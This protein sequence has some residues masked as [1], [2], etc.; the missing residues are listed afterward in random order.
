MQ[1][2][3]T[4]TEVISRLDEIIN[5]CIA[6]K[7]RLGYFAC[8][9]RKMTVAVQKG[10]NDGL[11]ADG[12]RMEKLD[13]IFANRYIDAYYCQSQR[14][15]TTS[16]WKAA[17]DAVAIPYTVIQH[18][19]LGMNAHINLD[20]GVAAAETSRG[21][22]IQLMKKD[23]DLINDIIGSL[24][25]IVQ[26]DLEEIC[27]PMKML[28]YVDNKSK[29]SVINF[30]ITAARNT[31]WVNAVGLST[32]LP[33]MYNPYIKTL[34]AKIAVVARNI[35]NPNFS[36]GLILRTVRTFEPKDVGQVIKFLKD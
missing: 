24:I 8:L 11:F 15:P 18:L 17:F 21:I 29:E 27:F 16:S 4:I 20:L 23:F 31:A 28:Q 34:D 2:A 10:I 3:K 30:S 22:D 32:V 6:K 36:Q 5:F 9:Y 13:V 25:N 26:K 1:P 7:S 12:A 14:T 33:N 19:L 35:I